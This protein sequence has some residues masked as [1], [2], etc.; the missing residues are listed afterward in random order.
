MLS[1]Y[2]IKHTLQNMTQQNVFSE[3]TTHYQLINQKNEYSCHTATPKKKKLFREL[4]GITIFSPVGKR[5]SRSTDKGCMAGKHSLVKL[6][7]NTSTDI[8]RICG[9]FYANLK[10]PSLT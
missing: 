6:S 5:T 7:M 8:N 9:I 10:Y 4:V 2:Y 3:M 1:F